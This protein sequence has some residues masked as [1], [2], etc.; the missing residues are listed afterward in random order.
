MKTIALVGNP[1]SGKTTIFNA[2]T[3]G[4]ERIGNWPGTTVERVEGQLTVNPDVNIVDLPGIYG[5]SAFS[6]DEKIARN[7]LLNEDPDLAVV[8][9][10]SSNLE[11]NLYLLAQVRELGIPVLVVFNMWDLAEKMGIVIDEKNFKILFGLCGLV[12]T[13]GIRGRGIDLLE[14]MILECIGN[15]LSANELK[16]DYGREIEDLISMVPA[17]RA[18]ALRVLEEGIDIAKDLK[19]FNIKLFNLRKKR[20]ESEYADPLPVILADKRHG[21][22]KGVI[23]ETVKRKLPLEAR[24][25]VS[26]KIDKV[27][28]NRVLGIP[29]FLFIMYLMFTSVFRVASPFVDLI[30]TLL[31]WFSSFSANLLA[32][33]HAPQLLISFIT[34]GII[35]GVGSVLVFLPNIFFLFLFIAILEDSGYLAR[36]AF[37]MDKLMHSLGLHGKS[38]IPMLIGFGCNIPGIMAARTLGNEKDRI[39]TILILPL[40]SCSARLPIYTLFASAFFKGNEGLV[41]FSLYALGIILAIIS[42]AILNRVLF[43]R[44]ESLLIM[45]MPP[46]RIPN[47]KMIMSHSLNRSWLFVKKAGTIIVAAVILVWILSNLPAG[48][49]PASKHSLLAKFGMLIAPVFK[50][51]GFGFWQASVAL[52]FG[53]VAKEIVVGSLGT[54]LASG[55][56]GALSTILP[57]YFNPASAYAFLVMSLVYIP[58]IATIAA[59]KKEIG[60]RW[61]AFSV[62]YTLVLGWVLSTVVFQIGRFFL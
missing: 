12:K 35:S 29:L 24:L 47:L 39:L 49:D 9:V 5:L 57:F 26:D 52:I 41:V 18:V 61:A 37:I 34:D 55:Q 62:V 15:K 3:G 1:N 14:K 51:A 32:S 25:Y 21:F 4:K 11:R 8:V 53:V 10:D 54:L 27:L 36:G 50:W 33:V 28:A 46:Y 58:C 40:M 31:S 23:S 7:F 30:E 17:K 48:V 13:V 6:L 20:L 44:Q 16:I 45:E 43:S 59:I 56:S 2:L 19:G 60:F 22:I 38:F 42:A